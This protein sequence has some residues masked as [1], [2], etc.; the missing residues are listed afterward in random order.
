MGLHLTVPH[1]LDSDM[2]PLCSLA[3]VNLSRAAHDLQ[4]IAQKD[5][6]SSTDLAAATRLVNEALQVGALLNPPPAC[7]LFTSSC[8]TNIK[9]SVLKPVTYVYA[10]C[11]L[12]C[13]AAAEML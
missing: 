8:Y 12:F 5:V 1:T 10:P 9:N 13:R 11:R 3:N 4:T 2:L 7:S 6:I